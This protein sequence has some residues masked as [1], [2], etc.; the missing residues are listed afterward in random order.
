MSSY[1]DLGKD[2]IKSMDDI[3]KLR[4]CLKSFRDIPLK[5]GLR[6]KNVLDDDIV[7]NVSNAREQAT[8]LDNVLESIMDGVRSISTDSKNSRFMS[9]SACQRV[10]NKFLGQ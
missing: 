8:A 5:K 4:D 9:K 10:V 1:K 2:V 6:E 3:K 7:K